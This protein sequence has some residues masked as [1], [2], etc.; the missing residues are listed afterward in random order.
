M[1]YEASSRV[2]LLGGFLAIFHPLFVF[3]GVQEHWP[4]LGRS[5]KT[6]H[7]L[8]NHGSDF[9]QDHSQVMPPFLGAI[10]I[11][12]HYDTEKWARKGCIMSCQSSKIDSLYLVVISK[13]HYQ[14]PVILG[15]HLFNEKSKSRVLDQT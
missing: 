3:R 2:S 14:S 15:L 11:P 8:L 12:D 6:C 1:N 10:Y 7:K 9:K 4:F 5:I 13:P